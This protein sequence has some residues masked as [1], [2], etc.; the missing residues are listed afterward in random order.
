MDANIGK[1]ENEIISEFG[2]PT[3][4]KPNG[5]E[6][7]VLSYMKESGPNIVDPHNP[8]RNTVNSEILFKDFYVNKE[9][10]VYLCKSNYPNQ[11]G[12]L[13]KKKT[14]NVALGFF[15]GSLIGIMR[16]TITEFILQ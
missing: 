12:P 15:F 3:N 8:Y 13:D 10:K 1:S 9:G 11:Q 16:F 2:T 14:R 6:G 7:K 5:A 4:I